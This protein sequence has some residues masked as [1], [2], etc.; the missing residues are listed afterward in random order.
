MIRLLVLALLLAPAARA[1]TVPE[2]DTYHG[3]P[4]R[5]PVPA[6]LAGAQVID[7]GQAIALQGQAAFLDVLPRP[8]AKPAAFQ[9]GRSGTSRP[10]ARFP[11]PNGCGTP[12][13][14]HCPLPRRR[15][16]ATD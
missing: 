8:K 16:C 12:G 14:K 2:P 4:Y 9:K 6:T 3:E 11:A 5:S 15:A 7:V 13:T 1:E 10:T